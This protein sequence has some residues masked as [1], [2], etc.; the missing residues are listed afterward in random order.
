MFQCGVSPVVL[1]PIVLSPVVLS[2]VL[3]SPVLLSPVVF[4]CGLCPRYYHPEGEEDFHSDKVKDSIFAFVISAIEVGVFL[5]EF[6]LINAVWT[7][8][9]QLTRDKV[10]LQ[11]EVVDDAN[12]IVF[13]V[14]THTITQ[15]LNV[16]FGI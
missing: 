2:P 12:N 7:L 8:F 13:R 6:L 11:V 16:F 3:L 5:T 4:Q 14:C 15:T 10:R 1:S 9:A